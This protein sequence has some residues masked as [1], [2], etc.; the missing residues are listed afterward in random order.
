LLAALRVLVL[1]VLISGA[2][3]N[4][5][6]AW[7]CDNCEE[8]GSPS[9]LLA[10]HDHPDT[11]GDCCSSPGCN[12]CCAHACAL[13][14]ALDPAMGSHVAGAFR[15]RIVLSFE[16]LAQSATFRPPIAA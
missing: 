4:S 15:S 2:L 5:A 9:A 1:G 16:P 13:L 14:P 8:P 12:Y 11:D 6:A 7:C 3:L 10:D